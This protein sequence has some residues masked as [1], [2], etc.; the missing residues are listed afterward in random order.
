MP[1]VTVLYMPGLT[2]RLTSADAVSPLDGVPLPKMK[3][4]K[5][6]ACPS[7]FRQFHADF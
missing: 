3:Q 5:D 7:I 2:L 1:N 4:L 6:V